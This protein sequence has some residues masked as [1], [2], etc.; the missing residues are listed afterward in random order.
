MRLGSAMSKAWIGS[1]PDCGRRQ[2]VQFVPGGVGTE[3]L[4]S[5]F[6]LSFWRSSRSSFRL[7]FRSSAPGME[8]L[9][10]VESK[11]SRRSDSVVA[12]FSGGTRS[13]SRTELWPAKLRPTA[14]RKAGFISTM[15]P[16]GL[17]R[18][19]GRGACSKMERKPVPAISAASGS[20]QGNGVAVF[21]LILC[22][23]GSRKET[24]RWS[25]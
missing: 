14:W 9:S 24:S 21:I 6:R 10:R 4:R 17:Q 23:G 19:A 11:R 13:Q 15:A 5:S 20:V 16:C 8:M 1:W 25:S 2:A 12:R 18:A 3:S 7:S 22:R